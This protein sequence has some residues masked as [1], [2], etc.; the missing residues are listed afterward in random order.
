[1]QSYHKRKSYRAHEVVVY[2]LKVCVGDS[3][4]FNSIIDLLF[5]IL[6]FLFFRVSS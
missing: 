1:M 5:N 2:I 3:L 6:E 4:V